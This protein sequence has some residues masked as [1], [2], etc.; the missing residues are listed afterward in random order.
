M[1]FIKKSIELFGSNRNKT[2]I[3]LFDSG[4]SINCIKRKLSDGDSV[5]GIGFLFYGGPFQ[6]HLANGEIVRGE[7]VSFRALKIDNK[8]AV[9]PE[10]IIFDSMVEDLIIGVGLMQEMKIILDPFEK[11]INMIQK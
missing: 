11:K 9:Y 4:S 10:L 6:S 1:G 7:R 2:I 3:A 5:D 8:I